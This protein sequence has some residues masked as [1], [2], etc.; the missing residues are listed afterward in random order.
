MS[1]FEAG[2]SNYIMWD[3][4]NYGFNP[5]ET[6]AL[7]IKNVIG[8]YH[9]NPAAVQSQLQQ[10]YNAGQ[11]KIAVLLYFASVPS[12]LAWDGVW[13][14]T[15]DSSYLRL[16][17]QHEQNLRDLLSTIYRVGFNEIF[18]RFAPTSFSNPDNWPNN[19]WSDFEKKQYQQNWNF[20]ANTILTVEAVSKVPVMYDLSVEA[21][22][23]ERMVTREYSKRLWSDYISVF[24]N[25]KS[26]GF[27]VAYLPHR[28]SKMIH[29]LL[30]TGHLPS[31]YAFDI[32]EH[33]NGVNSL[34]E[35]FQG[36]RNELSSFGLGDSQ[37][38]LQECFEADLTALHDILEARNEGI[39]VVTLFQWPNT[40]KNYFDKGGVAMF[41]NPGYSIEYNMFSNSTVSAPTAPAVGPI[42]TSAGQGCNDGQCLWITGLNFSNSC[43]VKIF[44]GDWSTG[45]APIAELN[46]QNLNC[47]NT[48]ITLRL[49][50]DVF[51]KYNNLNVLVYNQ[52]EGTWGQPLFV[53]I[54]K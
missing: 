18:F 2:G 16:R 17:P 14:I 27:S 44:P 12:T 23:S 13:G 42:V 37:I 6:T 21:G 47:S 50:P 3:I 24:G 29:D 52:N 22:G 41:S 51:F 10:M 39:N 53:N 1:P 32:Y 26:Y 30:T 15:N 38:I 7:S 36:I 28:L 35:A 20:I 40:K 11:R 48:L 33:T 8:T 34:K 43:G 46:S 31:K 49:P 25:Q 19:D 9:Q 45:N 5:T 4:G 54:V